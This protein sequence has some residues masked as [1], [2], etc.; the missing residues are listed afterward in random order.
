M[1]TALTTPIL[2]FAVVVARDGWSI[3]VTEKVA[4]VRFGTRDSTDSNASPRLNL[5]QT[6][7]LRSSTSY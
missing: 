3:N 6:L 5:L 7:L 2:S 1:S 4:L